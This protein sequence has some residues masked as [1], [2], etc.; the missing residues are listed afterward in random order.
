MT[1]FDWTNGNIPT[2][3]VFN[4]ED[5]FD[6]KIRSRAFGGNTIAWQLYKD[7][8]YILIK[9]D[10]VAT[11]YSST[12]TTLFTVMNQ[13]FSPVLLLQDVFGLAI[14]AKITGINSVSTFIGPYLADNY[15]T[16]PNEN[17]LN[18]WYLR[19]C[20]ISPGG[21]GQWT[22]IGPTQNQICYHGLST[23]LTQNRFTNIT[24]L[25]LAKNLL[26]NEHDVYSITQ[27]AFTPVKLNIVTGNATKFILIK[28]DTLGENKPDKDFYITP[29]HP[30]I[31]DGKE[32]T[33]EKISTGEKVLLDNQ[34][35]YSICT[36]NRESILVNN[37]P[38]LTWSYYAWM[39]LYINHNRI[40]WH[41]NQNTHQ[42]PTL[43]ITLDDIMEGNVKIEKDAFGKGNPLETIF[44]TD[45][46]KVTINGESCVIT[47]LMDGKWVKYI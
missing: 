15:Y 46:Q 30:I 14:R 18:I 44:V 26:S 27:K 17:S 22:T 6:L 3:Q 4:N 9:F 24:E 25:T 23:I 2:E 29:G 47:Q 7:N 32:V 5:C 20:F 40:G 11:P 33:A 28:K 36:D 39:N 42:A 13:Q 34:E 37:L 41:D 10:F 16:A 19:V 35:V 43:E 21:V 1:I 45:Q 12:A 8:I 31:I 38:V